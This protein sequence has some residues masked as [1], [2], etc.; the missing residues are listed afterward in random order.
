[1][2]G[3][4][5]C[6]HRRSVRFVEQRECANCAHLKR[7][8]GHAVGIDREQ[9]RRCVETGPKS[10]LNVVAIDVL[11]ARLLDSRSDDR[12]VELFGAGRRDAISRLKRLGAESELILDTLLRATTKGMSPE[13]AAELADSAGLFDDEK[14]ISPDGGSTS[15]A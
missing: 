12:I 7:L 5:S 6:P 9:C 11:R 8:C 4:D 13:A 14:P 2:R 15:G 1:M 10:V 3:I